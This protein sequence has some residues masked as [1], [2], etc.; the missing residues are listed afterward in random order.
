MFSSTECHVLYQECVEP[1]KREDLVGGENKWVIPLIE[2][3]RDYAK[4]VSNDPL[5][6]YF[7]I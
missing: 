3:I 6:A 4:M 1:L 7:E 5:M 2:T